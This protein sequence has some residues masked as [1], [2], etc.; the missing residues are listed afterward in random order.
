MKIRLLFIILFASQASFAQKLFLKT[1][2]NDSVNCHKTILLST[3]LAY[4]LSYIGLYE[5][6]YKDYN[7]SKFHFFNDSKEWLQ[8]DKTGHF[9]SAY[10]LTK[11][12]TGLLNICDTKVRNQLLTSSII[13]FI[14]ISSIELFD[15]F[16]SGWGASATDL[17][18]N[19]MGVGFFVLQKS[20][21]KKEYF[22][23]KFSYN[24]NSYIPF[25]SDLYGTNKIERLL[26]D[27]N[28]QT[29]WISTNLKNYLTYNFI[30]AWLN[31]AFGYGAENMTGGEVNLPAYP[32]YK[33]TRQYYFSI[34]LDLTKINTNIK[35]LD[36]IIHQFNVIKFPMPTIEYSNKEFTFHPIYF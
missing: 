19:A 15:G 10:Y 23:P 16:S 20:I 7:L 1:I 34:D 26:K 36:T 12:Q 13:S 18:A 28:G 32:W 4:S 5:L 14:G 31:I 33:R 24:S 35:I 27:Y 22:V 6:W 11:Y 17:T 9:F 21:L 30:P 3:G 25:R 2:K 29:Y 8:I